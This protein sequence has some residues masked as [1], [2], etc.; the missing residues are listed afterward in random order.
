ML[1]RPASATARTPTLTECHAYLQQTSCLL[2]S[3]LLVKTQPLSGP[4][5]SIDFPNAP[6]PTPLQ[7]A[8]K[9]PAG[10]WYTD[11]SMG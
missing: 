10:T 2:N 7:P 3:P 6:D 8:K 11:G 9:I 4:V 1:H 5:E